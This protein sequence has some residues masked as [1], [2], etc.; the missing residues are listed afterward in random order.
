MENPGSTEIFIQ[1]HTRGTFRSTCWSIR[2]MDSWDPAPITATRHVVASL[3]IPIDNSACDL[4]LNTL[5]MTSGIAKVS[6]WLARYATPVTIVPVSIPISIVVMTIMSRMR[7][8]L[9]ITQRIP[10]DVIAI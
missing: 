8:T 5:A 3:G 9:V 4:F 10:A 6:S 2:N 1:R 7:I